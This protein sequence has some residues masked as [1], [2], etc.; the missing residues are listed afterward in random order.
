MFHGA[1]KRN[2][3]ASDD[4]A[5]FKMS[6]QTTRYR[7]VTKFFIFIFIPES[8]IIKEFLTPVKGKVLAGHVIQTLS[9]SEE[10]TCKIHCYLN[11]ICQSIN[12]SPHGTNGMW[13]CELSDT[14]EKQNPQSF[15]E[16]DNVKYYPTKVKSGIFP[17]FSNSL[18]FV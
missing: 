12:V 4:E 16:E 5:R 1:I 9:V 10:E 3:C 6:V 18:K 8:C 2:N 11:D 13:K 15:I 14:D 7:F 17:F